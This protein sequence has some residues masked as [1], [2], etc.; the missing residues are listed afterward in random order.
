MKNMWNVLPR[1]FFVLAPMEDVTDHAFRELIATHL[2]CP[3]VF[4]T[5]FTSSEGVC[6]AGR[7]RTI[8]RLKF[9][10][11]QRPIVA[12][13]WGLTPEPMYKVAVL[14]K[15]MGFDG[16]DI[17][18]GC[19]VPAVMQKGAG[20]YLIE[21]PSLAAEMIHAVREGADGIPVSVK[22]RIG[23]KRVTTEKWISHLL[24][25]N[26]DALTV[27]FRTAKQMSKVPAD[28]EQARSVIEIRDTL[29]PK[30]VVIGNGDVGSY[31]EG[32]A[33]HQRYKVDGIMIGRGIFTNPWIFD[34]S[35]VLVEH[36]PSDYIDLLK[37]HIVLF[38]NA[39]GERKHFDIMKKFF[40]M[41][42]RNF[43]GAHELRMKLME[44]KSAQQ[45]QALLSSF[46]P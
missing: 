41:Y 28:W 14:I 5:E 30:T 39:W 21:T 25:Q 1:P 11:N 46:T 35:K 29:A 9:S 37:Y 44:V 15:E 10:E 18:M 13:I 6:S 4:F 17:N 31:S 12:Q 2:P 27:H 8:H 42:I 23:F 43:S 19:P 20:A 24:G 3:E 40:K 26:I 32:C 7:E 34:R 16:I 36:S 22:T 45:A 33:L 38:E